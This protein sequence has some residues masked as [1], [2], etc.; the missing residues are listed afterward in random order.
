MAHFGERAA[1]RDADALRGGI[2][3]HQIRVFGF[4]RLQFAQQLVELGIRNRRIVEHVITVVGVVDALTQFGD[5]IGGS[6][7]L[8]HVQSFGRCTAGAWVVCG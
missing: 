7:G 1:R 5:A 8:G 2:G 6:L 3:R 4:Q